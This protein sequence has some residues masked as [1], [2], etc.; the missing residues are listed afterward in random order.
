VLS[1][2]VLRG[3]GRVK[4]FLRS[5]LRAWIATLILLALTV[6]HP[7]GAYSVFTHEQLIDLAWDG[8]IKPLLLARFP[9][10][11]PAQLVEAHAFAYGGA[12]IQDAGYYPFGHKFFSDLTH[13]TRSGDFVLSLLRNSRNVYE[14]AFAIGALSHYLGDNIGHQDTINPATAIEFPK[15]AREYGAVITYDQSPHSHVRTEFAFDVNAL[16]KRRFAPGAYLRTVGIRV[17]R[18]LLERAFAETYGLRLHEVLGDEL[19]A[20]RS[21]RSSLR[22]FLPRIAAAEV[23]IHRNHFPTDFPTPAFEQY[24]QEVNR[25]DAIHHWERYRRKKPT[26]M[27]EVLAVVIRILPRVG[28]LSDLAIRGPSQFTQNWYVESINRTLASYQGMLKQLTEDRE[29]QLSLP[30]RDLD[31]G[32]RVAPGAYPLTDDTYA[33]LL[34]QLTSRKGRTVP[35]RLRE[36]I[37]AFYSDLNAPFATKRNQ[38]AWAHVLAELTLLRQMSTGLPASP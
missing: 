23:V 8:S 37:L 17:P 31:T 6:A 28:A 26:L 30:D 9:A 1:C 36:N 35:A 11:T 38:H 32:Y 34:H 19:P 14:Y 29:A 3:P 25:V 2:S 33:K 5:P 12:T 18:P 20:L 4:R 15:L 24:Q 21:Y 10:T 22:S 16:S 27:I 13:Y 7:A